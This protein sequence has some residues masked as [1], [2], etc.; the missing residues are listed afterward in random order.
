MKPGMFVTTTEE[1]FL[2]YNRQ[3]IAGYMTA[4]PEYK[5]HIIPAV[6]VLKSTCSNQKPLPC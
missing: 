1:L 5:S 3:A 2:L 6:S 4:G